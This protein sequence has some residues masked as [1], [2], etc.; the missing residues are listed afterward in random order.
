[1]NKIIEELKDRG[2][3][4]NISNEEK[5]DKCITQKKSIYIGFDPS[6]KSLHLGNYVMIR[7]LQIFEKNGVKI[8]PV[9]GGATGQ[10]GDPSGKKSERKILDN[11]LIQSNIEG[12]NSQLKHLTNCSEIINNFDFYRDFNFLD[13]LRNVGK[14]F[15]V[16]YLISKDIVKN[17]LET[18]ISYA[19]FSYSLI[20]A[21]DWYMLNKHFNVG[22]QCG[23]SD[24][25]G[26]ITNGL[27][28]IRKKEGHEAIVAGLTINLITKSDGTKFGKSEK[29][30]I[31]I[32]KNITS[33]FEMYQF[34]FNQKDEDVEKL[35]KFLSNYSIIE[36]SNIMNQH[37]LNPS[38]RVG[39]R[40]LC[41]NI[42]TVIHGIE[43]YSKAVNLAELL[44]KEIYDSLTIKEIEDIFKNTPTFKIT[45]K[46]LNLIDILVDC[47]IVSSKRIAR[48][49]VKD[50][51]IKINGKVI[52][53]IDISKKNALCSK[54]FILKKG[55]KLFYIL[56]L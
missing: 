36:I 4:S 48:E 43:E 1:M 23:G 2:M 35:L 55:K 5:F 41:E 13:F 21:Y 56:E 38:S 19:E 50:K 16:S 51:S 42:I 30:A 15:N 14:D 47:K 10:I 40:K 6:F 18:G 28:Y 46:S 31:Y 3:L 49:L 33:V 8:L 29:G 52:N 32:D 53:N 54:Y 7:V 9:L 27:E 20:Q 44:F 26:N 45:E 34:L 11:D 25:W 37:N 17:R 39:Q 24:Q 12:I 22:I